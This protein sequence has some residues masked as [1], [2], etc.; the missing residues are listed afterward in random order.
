MPQAVHAIH[1]PLR[2]GACQER[3][4]AAGGEVQGGI[5]SA[6]AQCLRRR[7]PEVRSGHRAVDDKALPMDA[8][9]REK[10]G[11]VRRLIRAAGMA[12]PRAARQSV[13]QMSHQIVRIAPQSFTSAHPCRRAASAVRGPTAK[14]GTP[15][16]AAP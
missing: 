14:T 12:H 16:L 3:T 15:G 5:K 6:R 7:W 8:M 2:P 10:G 9:G 1:K 11:K 13:R 4:R